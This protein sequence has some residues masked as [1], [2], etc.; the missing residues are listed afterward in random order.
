[1]LWSSLEAGLQTIGEG[2]RDFWILLKRPLMKARWLLQSA[3]VLGCSVLLKWCRARGSPV[4]TPSR[5]MSS[6]LGMCIAHPIYTQALIKCREEKQRLLPHLEPGHKASLVYCTCTSPVE[7]II[8]V[9]LH[10]RGVYEDSSVVVDGNLVNELYRT[11]SII[12]FNFD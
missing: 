6:M 8:T 7:C 1:M 2:I 11:Y 3:M 9:S 10:Y 5:M 4:S 12:I